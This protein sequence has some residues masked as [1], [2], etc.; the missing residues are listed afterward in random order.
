MASLNIKQY[1]L[2]HIRLIDL[3]MSS[4]MAN[5]H[6]S[7]IGVPQGSV[8]GPLLFSLFVNDV[9]CFV[10]PSVVNLYADDTLL[11]TTGNNVIK[12]NERMQASLKEISKWYNGNKLVLNASKSKCMLIEAKYQTRGLNDNIHVSLNNVEIKQVK[13]V[14][15]LGVII[16][17]NL[18]WIEHISMLCKKLSF[19]ISQ[20]WLQ[21]K[22]C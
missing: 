15:Y 11:Y 5:Y 17:D 9:N 4:V 1:G 20:L 18:I 19:K 13:S 6:R 21:R 3:R 7:V 16:D 8:L 10:Y 14:K 2:K 12:V 22:Y